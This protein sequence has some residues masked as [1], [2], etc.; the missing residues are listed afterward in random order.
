MNLR[1]TIVNRVQNFENTRISRGIID[2]GRCMRFKFLRVHAI[3][4]HVDSQQHEIEG[5]AHPATHRHTLQKCCCQ[6]GLILC[7]AACAE[8]V[9]HMEICSGA[10]TDQNNCQRA[11]SGRVDFRYVVLRTQ[12]QKA[13]RPQLR[14]YS[15]HRP[16][17]FCLLSEKC[18]GTR[19]V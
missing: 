1:T 8:S 11:V 4:P 5:S 13:H 9:Q 12:C 15:H 16:V 19:R 6:P 2:D 17:I 10:I 3:M 7:R 14:R 18:K